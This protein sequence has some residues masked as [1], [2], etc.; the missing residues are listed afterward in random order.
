MPVLESVVTES[1]VAALVLSDV[2]LIVAFV[3]G[4]PN[5]SKARAVNCVDCPVIRLEDEGEMLTLVK[6]D[7]QLP[8][9]V[10]STRVPGLKSRPPLPC[11]VEC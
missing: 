11:A 10:P 6:C 4:W 8:K 5:W 7:G 2:K 1:T 3:T 9:A